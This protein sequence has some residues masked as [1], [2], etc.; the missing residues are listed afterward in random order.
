MNEVMNEVT[1]SASAIISYDSYVSIKS[2][3]YISGRLSEGW[4][5]TQVR[6]LDI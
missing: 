6:I 2:L 3:E 5:D 1:D 4:T